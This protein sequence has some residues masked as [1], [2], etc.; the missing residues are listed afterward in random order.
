MTLALPAAPAPAP[1]RQI[2]VGT[3]LACAAGA[4]LIGGMSGIWLIIRSR[5]VDNGERFPVDFVIPEVASNV[6]LMTIFGVCFFA[7][8]TVWA[9]RRRD[10]THTGLSLFVVA[11]MAIAFINAQ[12]F[13]YYTMAMP[14]AE[15]GYAGMFYAMTG[16]ILAL[17]VIGI[18]FTA[19]TAF[20]SLGG[21]LRDSEIAS[22]HA[23]YWY[24]VAV[25]YAVVWFVVYVTK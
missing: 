20:R 13:I 9:A 14:I 5:A 11:I 15:T 6:M 12:A 18:A 7:Q 16:T 22:A 25:A 17:V 8:W 23:L 21:R 1:R 19:V 2:F 24:F 4:M 3:A 10:R